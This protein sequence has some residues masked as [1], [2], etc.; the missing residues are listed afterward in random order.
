MQVMQVGLWTCTCA[1]LREGEGEVKPRGRRPCPSG[2]WERRA[3]DVRRGRAAG[4]AVGED[5]A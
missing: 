5:G 1:G 4:A 3:Q 2:Q